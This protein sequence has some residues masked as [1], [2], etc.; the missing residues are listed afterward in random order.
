MS[1]LL[2]TCKQRQTRSYIVENENLDSEDDL[3]FQEPPIALDLACDYI[4]EI[5]SLLE[6]L[7]VPELPTIGP[8]LTVSAFQVYLTKL[9]FAFKLL[10]DKNK[11]QSNL[12][13]WLTCVTIN[14]LK[15]LPEPSPASHP[16]SCLK[17]AANE[18]LHRRWKPHRDAALPLSERCY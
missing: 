4:T 7:V 9:R 10:A 2:P 3:A 16:P 12:L 13:N 11:K 18:R 14:F 8:P 15:L 5:L 6:T 17:V 1:V